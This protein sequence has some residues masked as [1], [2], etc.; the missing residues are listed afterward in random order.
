M[1]ESVPFLSWF[2]DV[3]IKMVLPFICCLSPHPHVWYCKRTCRGSLPSCSH[4]KTE[5]FIYRKS[6]VACYELWNW[7]WWVL[8]TRVTQGKMTRCQRCLC[9]TT[10][11]VLASNRCSC[12]LPES[13]QV[14]VTSRFCNSWAKI[15]KWQKHWDFVIF[16][17]AKVKGFW[18]WTP[19][20]WRSTSNSYRVSIN[21]TFL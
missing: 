11:Q 19:G 4:L 2:V 6:L 18:R 8:F 10:W 3:N 17:V 12:G 15:Q 9:G 21:C 14:S 16:F 13:H 7:K 20:E 1:A 5:F